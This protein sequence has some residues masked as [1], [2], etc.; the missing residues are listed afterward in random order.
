MRDI[1]SAINPLTHWLY[2]DLCLPPG[3]VQICYT[4]VNV[5]KTRE[6]QTIG[7]KLYAWAQNPSFVG[8]YL[9]R[10]KQI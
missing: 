3:A 8:N 2:I 5:L 1:G 4:A 10:Y 9:R 6:Y 7:W